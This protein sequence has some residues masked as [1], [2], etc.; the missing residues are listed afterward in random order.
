MI[1]PIGVSEANFKTAIEKF[2]KAIGE[3]WV[4]DK[5]E[6]IKLYRDAYS[7]EWD[8]PT[9][10]IPSLAVAPKDTAEVQAIVKIAN[11]YKIPLFPIST[12]KNLGY[13]S[14]APNRRGDVV[15]D[16]KRMNKIIEVDDKRNFCILE[17]GVSYFDF[18]EYCEKNNL[19]VM[20]DIPDP[21][22]GSP[23]GNA[24]DHGWGYTYGMYRDHFGAHCGMEV[25]LANGEVMRTGMGALPNA[26]TFAENKYGYGA[27]VDGLFAQSNFGI[28][29]KMGFWLMPKPEFYA[30]YSLT[31]PRREDII[32]MVEIL[33]YLEDSFIIGW[34]LYRSPLNP[35]HG[36][37]M[38]PELKSYL[39]SNG[40]KPD[41]EKIQNYALKNK[42]PYWQID[43]PIYGNKDSVK[44]NA[45]YI[46]KRFSVIDGSKLELVQE[47]SLPLS[48]DDIE[49]L[50]HKVS[51]GIPSMEIFWLSTRGEKLDPQDGH[52]W[53]SPI[54]P[55]DGK[56]LLKCQDV[57]IDVFHEL[58]MPSPITPFAHPRSWMYRAFCFMLG[59][60]NSRTDIEHNKKMR[61]AYRKM[62][63]VAAD[64]GWGDY[65]AAPTFQDDV[66]DVYSYNDHILKKFIEKLKDAI[67]PNGI[68]APGR[69]GIWPKS[70]REA[71]NGGAK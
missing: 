63:E 21:G 64:N 47:F 22:W 38:N 24:L 10:P 44:A 15:V 50:K 12:G 52:V 25:V 9:E 66:Y 57:Y 58:G 26:K 51:L 20:M 59:F 55:R 2:K 46:K 4:F 42:I 69:G 17:P 16:L 27:Y 65:R 1:L 54:I 14:S 33:N 48:K 8:E 30:L 45:E 3:K 11:E 23:V 40:G 60:G 19:N 29:T 18:Y 34:P 13:G 5:E 71:K 37:E 35:P 43:I 39:T 70:L 49:K 36:K 53:F 56:E 28:V 41:L 62:I 7:P 68:M 61:I 31:T 6:D 67:D 32:P